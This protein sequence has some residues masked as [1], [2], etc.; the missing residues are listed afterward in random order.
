MLLACSTAGEKADGGAG[1]A[2]FA[3]AGD[4]GLPDVWPAPTYWSAAATK[5]VD[6]LNY[7][8]VGGADGGTANR[9][10]AVGYDTHSNG[11]WDGVTGPNGCVKN[12][13]GTYTGL[14]NNIVELNE[15]A[16]E[17]GANFAYVWSGRDKLGKAGGKLYGIWH[18]DYGKNPPPDKDIIPII[19][20]G[21]GE[22]DMESNKDK[23]IAEL[24][25]KFADFKARTGEYSISN[26][27]TLP[28]YEVMP[29][30]S[31]H[32][33]GRIAGGGDGTGEQC[34]DAQA[35]AFTQATSMMIGDSYT[36]VTNRWDEKFNDITG[37]KGKQ[38]E[39]YDIWLQKDDK[40]HRG[41]FEAAWKMVHS[42][43]SRSKKAYAD[44]EHPTVSW[45]WMQGHA[46]NDDIGKAVCIKGS[47]DLW[48]MG[49]FPTMAYLRKEICS[50][51]AAGGTGI[52][53]F[54]YQYCRFPEA[55]KV[56]VFFRALSHPE[57]Y[58]PA[59]LSP[60]LDVGVDTAFMGEP[61][62]DGKGRVHLLVKWHEATKTAYVIGANPGARATPF[63]LEFPWTLAKVE[64]LD[65]GQ[66][67]PD[68]G[69][70]GAFTPA[71]FVDA[72]EAGIYD[73]TLIYTAPIDDGFIF[74]VT[75]L[76]K[77]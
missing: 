37:Q 50:T 41:Y 1:D 71:K 20:N 28:P 15:L 59:L 2:G 49:T 32:P 22:A 23:R 44:P 16:Y 39:G 40:D 55:E 7:V 60:W 61:G 36:Y 14:I 26:R 53:F 3:D 17:A 68:E 5:T 48:A 46:F 72:P 10:F 51:I 66:P 67:A 74:R 45:A 33:T 54:G 12:P 34:T 11:P 62:Y 4:G 77:N 6:D 57:V 25:A 9:L 21:G 63:T 64:V 52:I 43:V 13:D 18:D 47:S 27:P 76:V 31:W 38:G 8:S 73:K 19:F 42:Q 56:R 30:W 75:P 29:W 24:K 70:K 35:D 58:G 69:S 65:W